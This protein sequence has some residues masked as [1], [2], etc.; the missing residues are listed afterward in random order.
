MVCGGVPVG[1]LPRSGL[2]KVGKFGLGSGSGV[3]D[4]LIMVVR[5]VIVGREVESVMRSL[6]PF[7]MLG[8]S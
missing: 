1:I 8:L 6:A 2:G 3:W 5:E 4:M 7:T